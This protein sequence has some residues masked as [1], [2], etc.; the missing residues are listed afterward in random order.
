[1]VQIVDDEVLLAGW[2]GLSPGAGD[3]GVYFQDDIPIGAHC[4][5]ACVQCLPDPEASP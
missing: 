4:L 1:M 3:S 2:L 5:A